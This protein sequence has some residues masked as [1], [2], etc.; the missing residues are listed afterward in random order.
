MKNML[1]ALFGLLV[2]FAAVGPAQAAVLGFSGPLLVIETDDGTGRYA[3]AS[4][5]DVFFGQIDD[6]SFAGQISDGATA[7]VFGCCI[8]AGGLGLSNDVTVD[9]EFAALLN[10]ILG[11]NVYS[12]GDLVDQVDI[13]GDVIIVGDH[14]IEVGLSYVL[15]PSTFADESATNYPF[16]PAKLVTSLYFVL[17]QDAGESDIFSAV[18]LVSAVPWPDSLWLM[19]AGLALVFFAIRRRDEVGPAQP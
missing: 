13:E 15:D 11:A 8:A 7:T 18:G 17:E 5:G 6:G 2:S 12:A 9:S 4:I 14:R 3:G 1:R 16:D 19:S 10:G